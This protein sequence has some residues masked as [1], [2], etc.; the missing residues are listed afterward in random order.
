VPQEVVR[1]ILD[2]DS[3]AMTAHYARLH[4]STVREHWERAH[5]VNASGETVTLDPG[6]PL[7]DATWA[8]QRLGRATQALPNGYCGLPI[9]QR[10]PHANAPPDLPDVPHH[11]RVP[12]PASPAAPAA[13]A[14]HPVTFQTI[15]RT[16]GVSRSWL[17]GQP[18]LRAELERLRALSARA[19]SS[20]PVPARQCAT[21]TSLRRRLQAANAQLR[22]LREEPAAPPAARP[23]AR[24]APSSR[25][26]PV[27]A[28]R[29]GNDRTVL[30]R[31]W[32]APLPCDA[33]LSRRIDAGQ[34]SHHRP[35][36]R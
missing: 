11:R 3:P 35:R 25:D 2:H 32:A 30:M 33:H 13:A 6:G 26:P 27:R 17:Y 21:D 18:D 23:R 5:K 28:R 31:A 22:Q 36:P 10:C 19:P 34:S 9:Q 12:A 14:A 1:K 15:A 8:K 16:A 24:S 7:A 29:L 20:P 4:D